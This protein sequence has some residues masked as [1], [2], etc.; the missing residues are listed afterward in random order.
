MWKWLSLCLRMF[1]FVYVYVYCCSGRTKIP[2]QAKQSL[3]GLSSCCVV[4]WC[5]RLCEML[6]DTKEKRE[7]NPN[8][9]IH[10][11][12]MNEIP[13]LKKWAGTFH[14]NSNPSIHLYMHHS[15]WRK[16]LFYVFY[17]RCDLYCF[18]TFFDDR[19]VLLFQR[20][21][22]CCRRRRLHLKVS[23]VGEL[24]DLQIGKHQKQHQ[25][26]L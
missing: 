16:S 10:C 14:W 23:R 8:R 6:C 25:M 5:E 19:L 9:W 26:I 3:N 20:R 21:C 13:P 4:M 17:G 24:N 1:V 12:W 2:L 22:R 11:E 7:E 15:I 18:I